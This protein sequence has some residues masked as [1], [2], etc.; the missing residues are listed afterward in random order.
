MNVP[1]VAENVLSGAR[2]LKA[3]AID[4]SAENAANTARGIIVTTITI[5]TIIITAMPCRDGLTRK[6]QFQSA[7]FEEPAGNGGL[8]Y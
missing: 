5:A 4:Q 6:R 7:K 3:A 1:S 8:F 2:A